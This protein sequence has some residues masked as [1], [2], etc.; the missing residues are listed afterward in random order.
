MLIINLSRFTD[1]TSC[2]KDTL[3]GLFLI[4]WDV[5]EHAYKVHFIVEINHTTV[6]R[7]NSSKYIN[8]VA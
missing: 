2:Q 7:M 3:P 8:A 4:N 1:Y 6:S 5:L